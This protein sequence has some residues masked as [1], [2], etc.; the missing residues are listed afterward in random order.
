MLGSICVHTVGESA[1]MKKMFGVVARVAETKVTV[2]VTGES[3]TGKEL[4]ARAL[5]A[6]SPRAGG[7]FVA[8][9]CAVIP[10]SLLESELFGRVKGAFTGA[11]AARSGLFV[12]AT[13]GTLFLD[14]VA[15]MPPGMQAK[16]LR[17]LQ[18]RAVRPVGG[19]AETAFDARIVAATNRELE[20]EVA[21]RRFRADLFYRINVVHVRI[22]PLR[23]RENDVLL[24]AQ[25]FLERCQARGAARVVGFKSAA[26]ER[27]VRYPWPGNVRELQN[28]IE[29][30]VA[31]SECDRIGVEDLPERVRRFNAS[32]L[33]IDASHHSA[34]LS[35]EQVQRQHVVQVLES[36]GSP[37]RM[38]RALPFAERP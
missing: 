23:E 16:L 27:L 37:G 12:K 9:N 2:L 13:G 25:S 32:M 22:P 3:G 30:A 1:A 18:E 8:I 19:D 17:A 31:L 10:E 11:R 35:L 28:C 15:E 6:R 7:P 5:H 34:S 21:E 24:L 14:E 29:C 4:V 33:P 26:A 36:L 38:P 20:T